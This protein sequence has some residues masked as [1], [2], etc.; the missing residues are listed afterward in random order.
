[1]T[2]PAETLAHGRVQLRRVRRTDEETLYRLINESLSHLR[3]WM[4]WVSP[5]GEHPRAAIADFLTQAE[6][7]WLDGTA[8]SYAILVSDT[9][10]GVC[11]LENRL[12]PDALEIGYWLHPAHTGHGYATEATAALITAAFTLPG[13]DRVQIWHDAANTPSG[14]VPRRLGFTRI[15]RQSPP[16]G[17]LTPGEIGT[18]IIWELTRAENNDAADRNI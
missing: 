15:A 5:E 18:D 7:N 4:A 12:G 13:I 8:Y 3:P 6:Q 9:M 11:G 14:G 10:I 2:H 17:P 16:R 1:M